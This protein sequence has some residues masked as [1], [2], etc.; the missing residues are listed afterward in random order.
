[1]TPI[2]V[3]KWISPEALSLAVPWLKALFFILFAWFFWLVLTGSSS[4]RR[5]G[6]VGRAHRVCFALFA[7][8]LA[9]V[10]VYQATW[11]LSGFARAEFVEFMR[12]YNR[13]PENPAGRVARGTITDR[14]GVALARTDLA[15]GAGRTYPQGEAFAHIVGYVHPV[16]GLSGVERAETALLSGEVAES[17]DE[18]R[19]FGRNLLD[20]STIL[21]HDITLTLD[22]DLQKTAW[23]GFA[24]RRGAVVALDP[25]DG[26]ILVLVSSPSFDPNA[27]TAELFERGEAMGS[28]LLNRALQGLYPP[29]SAFKPLVAALALEAGLN[30][31]ID[32][33]AEGFVAGTGNQPIRDHEY[34]DHQ[35]RGRAWAGHGT[36]GMREAM[37]KSSNI[38]FARLGLMI[39]GARLHGGAL[40]WGMTRRWKIL[41][42]TSGDL[43][44]TPG[45]IPVLTDEAKAQ[46]AQISIGQGELVVTPLDM[47]MM[48]SAIAR[49]GVVWQPRLSPRMPPAPLD[50]VMSTASARTLAS[51]LRDAVMR[52]TGVGA[53]IPGLMVAGKTGT[54]QNSSGKDHSWFVC[55]APVHD[56]VI[57]MAVLVEQ[58]GYGSRAAVPIAASLLRQ[59]ETLGYFGERP[60]VEG[61]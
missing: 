52:G 55:F 46:T 59:A 39:G 49:G 31:M 37:N 53:D 1:M 2:A 48:T 5:K 54:A 16:Y 6:R 57:A 4:S 41:S 32:C 61:R 8:L 3:D 7:G 15:Q 40:N 18:W 44:S 38:Y 50:P 12:K 26:S 36:I 33:P 35:R 13:R 9:A 27:L 34:Y 45:R 60:G 21:G 23:T 47:A 14:H 58:G 56:P 28:P 51:M 30:P 24:G 20:R 43:V 11:Q 25:R 22:A 10:F 42:G 19:R 29:G 17:R